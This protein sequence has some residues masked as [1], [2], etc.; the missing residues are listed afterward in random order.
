MGETYPPF[1]VIEAVYMVWF[2]LEFFIRLISSPSKV[3]SERIQLFIV[4]NKNS[5]TFHQEFHEYCGSAGDP[6]I[7]HQPGLLQVETFHRFFILLVL[8]LFRCPLSTLLFVAPSPDPSWV[9]ATGQPLL[10]TTTFPPSEVRSV[11]GP[12]LG[13]GSWDLFWFPLL[14]L[15]VLCMT[16]R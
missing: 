1:V 14:V 13:P 5:D 11:A 2:T 4:N 16:S 12:L 10:A 7:L 3:A 9:Q 8:S 6:T 15:R